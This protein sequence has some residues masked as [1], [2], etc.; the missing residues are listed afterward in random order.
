[1]SDQHGLGVV[2][3]PSPREAEVRHRI[4]ERALSLGWQVV[5][6]EVA[7]TLAPFPHLDAL[8]IIAPN[9]TMD[10]CPPWQDWIVLADRPSERI[11]DLLANSRTPGEH[12][13][14][15]HPLSIRFAS[16]A[17]IAMVSG[18][19]MSLRTERLNLPG[20]GEVEVGTHGPAPRFALSECLAIYDAL[21]VPVGAECRWSTDM[22]SYPMGEAMEG[23]SASIDLTGRFRGVIFGPFVALIPGTWECEIMIQVDPE[24]ARAHLRFEW[25]ADDDFVHDTV[26]IE[27]AGVYTLTLTR[28]WLSAQHAQARCFVSQPHFQG[29]M[30]FMGCRIKRV[31]DTA[32]DVMQ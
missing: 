17:Q 12:G 32:T 28:T 1:M 18:K 3:T 14:W 29:R 5:P 27:R 9:G 19:V 7:E 31:A 21:P 13:N 20:I 22:F 30:E 16:A 23:G 4:T 10:H 26:T 2:L 25:G 24:R 15:W 8:V 6:A 11:G